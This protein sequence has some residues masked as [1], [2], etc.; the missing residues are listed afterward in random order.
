M[1]VHGQAADAYDAERA[2]SQEEWYRARS[3]EY[4]AA[5]RQGER[6]RQAL[7]F[8]AALCGGVAA[9]DVARGTLGVVA[10]VLVALSGLITGWMNLMGFRTNAEL[11]HAAE[12]GLAHLRPDRPRPE[13]GSPEVLAYVGEVERILLGEVQTWSEKWRAPVQPTPPPGEP[14]PPGG[15]D[16]EP[17]DVTEPP[18][19]S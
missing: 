16:A 12:G 7:L 1:T 15:D 19:G 10:A 11:Y 3:E 8:L 17:D 9:F 4:D 18:P 14:Q 13:A 5:D 2:R 6:V